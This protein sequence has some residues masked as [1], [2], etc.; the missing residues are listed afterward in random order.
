MAAHE[1]AAN[2][3]KR[4]HGIGKGKR[5]K[6]ETKIEK[7]GWGQKAIWQ[8]EEVTQV[9]SCRRLYRVFTAARWKAAWLLTNLG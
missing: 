6:R 1:L 4:R 7:T 5:E 8:Q 3:Y 2:E 9:E